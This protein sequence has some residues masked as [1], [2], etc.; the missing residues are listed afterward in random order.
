[1]ERRKSFEEMAAYL[2]SVRPV[3]PLEDYMEFDR[4]VRLLL[5]WFDAHPR[6]K[7]A[8][9][10]RLPER[11]YEYLEGVLGHPPERYVTPDFILTLQKYARATS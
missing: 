5:A 4:I 6:I 9:Q 3:A 1:M 2:R 8:D 11:L 7:P 10:E